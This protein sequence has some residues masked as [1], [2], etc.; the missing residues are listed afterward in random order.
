MSQPESH[1]PTTPTRLATLEWLQQLFTQ[2][3]EDNQE[4]TISGRPTVIQ[5]GRQY[6]DSGETSHSQSFE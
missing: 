4:Q 6:D 5:E 1:D 2:Q 3:S